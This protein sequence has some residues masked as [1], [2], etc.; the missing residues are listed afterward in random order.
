[1]KLKDMILNFIQ[2]YDFKFHSKD[3]ILNNIEF[4]D[5]ELYSKI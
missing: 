3:M 2:R 4:Y 5:F 1:M